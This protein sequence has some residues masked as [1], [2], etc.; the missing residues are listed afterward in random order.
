MPQKMIIENYVVQQRVSMSLDAKIAW[1]TRVIHTWYDQWDGLVY[2]A[3]SGGLDS[4][5]M[6]HLVRSLYPEVPAV[7]WD[8]GLEFPEIRDFVKEVENCEFRKPKYTFRE[9]LEKYGY[10]VIS[11]RV[12]QG[13]HAARI[14]G[15]GT[16][17]WRLR[18]EGIRRNGEFSKMSRIPF[19]WQFLLHAPFKVSDKCCDVMKKRPAAQYARE[20]GRKAF[21]GISVTESDG[22]WTTYQKYGCN[23]FNQKHPRSWPL[24]I[25]TREN[26]LEYIDKN[27][28]PYSSIY[29]KG[30]T[31]TGCIFCA[32]GAHMQSPNRFELLAKTHPKQWE[33]CMNK[34]GLREVLNVCDIPTGCKSDTTRVL[35][36]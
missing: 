26:V 33:Y 31:R 1:A 24:A 20:T 32:F 35:T 34:L 21:V 27:S 22:R 5:A 19:K 16:P 8:T 36:T 2:V 23:A 14:A 12:A 29:D 6:L 10:P 17:T 9:T 7:F 11:K 25:W 18:T 13:I 28:I 30:Y 3:F 15:E 4:T